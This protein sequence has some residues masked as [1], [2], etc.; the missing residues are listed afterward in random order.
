LIIC[1]GTFI[2]AGVSDAVLTV[3]I[4]I[5]PT[6]EWKETLVDM[7]VRGNFEVFICDDEV[8][9][10]EMSLEKRTYRD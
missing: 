6:K 2:W 5:M 10:E 1:A 4:E 9:L 7:G 8:A 3:V